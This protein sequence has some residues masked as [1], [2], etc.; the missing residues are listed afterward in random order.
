[1]TVNERLNVSGLL[2][3][4]DIAARARDR[5]CMIALLTATDVTASDAVKIVEGVLANP[6][7]FG[8]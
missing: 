2:N 8:F 1:M 5:E 7:R 6:A 3:E 4:W